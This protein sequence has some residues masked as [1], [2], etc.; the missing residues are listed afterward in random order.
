MADEIKDAALDLKEKEEAGQS[1]ETEETP[2]SAGSKENA[3]KE[4]KQKKPTEL[5]KLQ[6]DYND[7]NDRYMRLA[8]EYDNYRKRSARE[9]EQ[10]WPDATAAAAAQFLGVADNFERAINAQCTD[11]EFKKGM[12]M[13]F[14][15]LT[16]ALAKLGVA[17]FGEEGETFD[18][19]RHNAVM[20]VD[21]EALGEGEIV[22]VLQKGYSL[23][24]RVLRCAMVKV[25][26]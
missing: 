14:R 17:A 16:D 6:T 3:K 22:Q 9:R 20:H 25:A 12:E 10:I 11:P 7:L 8:A 21:D 23:G 2:A 24:D 26:N 19:V 18:P 13:T 15:S 5:E 1:P 4:K